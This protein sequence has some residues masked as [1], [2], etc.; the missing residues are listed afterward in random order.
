MARVAVVTGAARGIG[1]AMALGLIE[2]G[3]AVAALDVDEAGLRSLG[4]D[5]PADRLL[6]ERC[7][8]A[9]EDQVAAAIGRAGGELG[10]ISALVNDAAL[11][12]PTNAPLHELELAEWRRVTATNLDGVFLCSKHALPTL[13]ATRGAIVNIASTRALMS[14]P[15]G[16]AYGATKGAVIAFTHALAISAGPEVR[17]NCISPGWI[18]TS[19][20]RPGGEPS[21]FTPEDHAQHPVGRVG[22]CRDVVDL[23][24][25]LLSDRAG[26]VTGQN[27]V[28]DGGMTKKMIYVE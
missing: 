20:H 17:V 15:N 7:D 26:F 28:V 11:T 5:A 9:D 6:T 4:E 24:V 23:C 16:E 8:V 21:T 10:G 18:D 19:D 22:R 13:R 2:Q 12:H 27:F 14:E 1:R 25:Y 3:Y